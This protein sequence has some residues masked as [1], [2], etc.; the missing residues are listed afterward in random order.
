MFIQT[1]H[2]IQYNGFLTEWMVRGNKTSKY[3]VYTIKCNYKVVQF[4]QG[5]AKRQG[6]IQG[7]Y[8]DIFLKRGKRY[9]F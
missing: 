2:D 3:R 1:K 9:F 4:I 8:R 6:H 5:G 7:L